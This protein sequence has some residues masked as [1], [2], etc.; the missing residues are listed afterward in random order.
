M[1][2]YSNRLSMIAKQN[3]KNY[4]NRNCFP[5]T[6]PEYIAINFHAV[7]QILKTTKVYNLNL[8]P[9]KYTNNE[10]DDIN[11][12]SREKYVDHNKTTDIGKMYKSKTI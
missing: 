3:C 11:F 1:A 9:C 7:K 10:Y 2:L 5:I 4:L 8:L 6:V 12:Q